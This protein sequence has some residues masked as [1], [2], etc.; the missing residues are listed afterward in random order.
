MRG[1]QGAVLI[2]AVVPHSRRGAEARASNNT[3]FNAAFFHDNW[4]VI[5]SDV[6]EAV[7]S[8]FAKGYLLKEWN[9]TTLTLVPKTSCPDTMRDYRPI[10][11]CNVI[12]KCI[13]KVLA[14]RLQSVLPLV[15]N[16]S[17]AER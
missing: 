12:Y 15:I 3:G 4:D 1:A 14:G 7:K 9:C 11:S 5:G 13:T 10:A 6:V 16:Q 2:K 8:F 17:K